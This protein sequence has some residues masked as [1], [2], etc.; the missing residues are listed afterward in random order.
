MIQKINEELL[1][2]IMNILLLNVLE[3][4]QDII[5]QEDF[6]IFT[7][8][9]IENQNNNEYKNYSNIKIGECE[10][11][12]KNFYNIGQ[13]EPLF[14]FK[15]DFCVEGFYI[16]IIEYEIFYFYISKIKLD[17]KKCE[18]M[19]INIS[20][21]I[22]I[23]EDKLYIHNSSSDFYTNICFTYKT[24]FGT[25]I[26]LTDRGKDFINQ[27]L[28]LCEINCNY[29]GYTNEKK[30]A[31]CEC[32][33]K[34]DFPFISQLSI[35]KD[36]LLNNFVDIKKTMNIDVL[37]CYYLIFTKDG[38]KNNFGSYIILLIIILNILL[39]INFLIKGYKIFYHR[40]LQMLTQEKRNEKNK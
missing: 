26:T 15:F 6:A 7:L 40:I 34:V 17:L 32:L 38:F 39:L 10:R 37:K 24:E 14:M 31:L 33:I 1:N 13:E 8:T 11:K 28:S 23:N 36:K 21:P 20:I 30:E 29:N 3:K 19:K 27:N 25:D 12:L 4:K 35:D 22:T 2:G 18:N 16:P 5:V 9:T